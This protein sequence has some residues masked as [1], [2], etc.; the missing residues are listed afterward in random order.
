MGYTG[1]FTN[2]EFSEVFKEEV[3]RG[4]EVLEVQR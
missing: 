4:F 1:I 3:V 2:K